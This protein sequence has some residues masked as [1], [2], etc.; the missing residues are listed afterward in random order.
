MNELEGVFGYRGLVDFV[1]AG[2]R[3]SVVREE[4]DRALCG[5][6]RSEIL[7]CIFA[8]KQFFPERVQHVRSM[9]ERQCKREVWP[10][11]NQVEGL[12]RG[13]ISR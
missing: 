7:A 1:L 10:K 2:R 11:R 6:T 9:P 4:Y 5:L 3:V 13:R 8:P 12:V